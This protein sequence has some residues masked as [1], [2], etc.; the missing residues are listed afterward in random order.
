MQ[1]KRLQII[2]QAFKSD[3]VG[4][5]WLVLILWLMKIL[6]WALLQVMLSIRS[7]IKMIRAGDKTKSE[8]WMFVGYGNHQLTNNWF[9]RGNLTAGLNSVLSKDIRA[10]SSIKG[11]I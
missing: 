9:I 3:L 6:Y 2:A 4:A 8:S 1:I 11:K 7:N 5:L 10:G